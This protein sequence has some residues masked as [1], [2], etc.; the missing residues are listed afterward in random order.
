MAGQGRLSSNGVLCRPKWVL[1]C[2]LSGGVSSVFYQGTREDG[3]YQK[4]LAFHVAQAPTFP[5]VYCIH[6]GLGRT[7][8]SI[9]N[10]PTTRSVL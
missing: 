8:S 2:G 7:Y 9:G 5:S 1:M 4:N 3:E 6:R 10:I